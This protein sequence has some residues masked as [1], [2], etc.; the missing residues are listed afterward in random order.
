MRYRYRH[1]RTADVYL[2]CAFVFNKTTNKNFSFLI[3]PF[4]CAVKLNDTSCHSE[5]Q[6]APVA[7]D[8]INQGFVDRDRPLLKQEDY[9]FLHVHV[10]DPLTAY[11][12]LSE[13]LRSLCVDGSEDP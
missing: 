3:S 2:M 5:A 13:E 7:L 1:N 4:R 9:Q 12:Y 6:F 8:I 10:N 11:S